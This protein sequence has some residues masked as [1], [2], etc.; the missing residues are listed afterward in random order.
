MIYLLRHAETLW[1]FQLR[2]QGLDDSPLTETGVRQA[3]AY[4][5]VLGQLIPGEDIRAGNVPLHASPLGR[6]R[7]TAQY[8]IDALGFPAEAVHFEPRLIEFDYG[9]WSGLTNDEIEQ[10]FPG[11]LEERE[12]DKW[13]YTVPNGE[14]YADVEDK[15]DRWMDELPRNRVIVAVT[16]SVVS[17]VIR[18]RYLD[19]ERDVAG[20]LDHP[21]H[22]I[23][24]LDRGNVEAI[25]IQQMAMAE[26]VTGA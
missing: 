14:S 7:R 23:F 26:D 4:A 25:D 11:A 16:H 10:H 19:M 17:R 18:R 20:Q 21:Q 12:A 2:K 9:D 5:G 13:F 3:R 1:N 8:L 24:R 22:L 6:T 15:V